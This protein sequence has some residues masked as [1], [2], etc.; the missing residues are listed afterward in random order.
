MI[1]K[2]LNL[3]NTNINIKY[4]MTISNN[5]TRLGLHVVLLVLILNDLTNYQL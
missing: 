1:F 5:Y 4:F 2:N 3:E